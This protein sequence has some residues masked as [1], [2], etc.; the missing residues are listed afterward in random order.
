MWEMSVSSSEGGG[1]V[2][3]DAAH[4]SWQW[5]EAA[6]ADLHFC[7]LLWLC[8]QMV[9]TWG[10][11]V[12]QHPS[13]INW[14][15]ASLMGNTLARGI[16]LRNR[17]SRG[18]FFFFFQSGKNCESL[19]APWGLQR[20]EMTFISSTKH[21]RGTGRTVKGRVQELRF[22]WLL[23]WSEGKLSKVALGCRD[24]GGEHKDP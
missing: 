21:N 8:S 10:G 2:L 7:P 19:F 3:S 17:S 18:V 9:A 11:E 22:Q 20:S 4:W 1:P 12:Q 15:E 13:F 24:E 6:A 5:S 16:N 23:R 14:K